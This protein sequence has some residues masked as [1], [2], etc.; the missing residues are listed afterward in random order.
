MSGS[1]V[2]VTA[3]GTISALALNSSRHFERLLAGHSALSALSLP[4]YRN[5][6]P[7]LQASIQDFDR[8]ELIP[9]RML[10][11]LLSPSPA[12]ALA[13]TTEAL[14]NAGLDAADLTGCGLY[15][16]SVC[17]DANPEALIP[18]LRAS[19]NHL[20]ELDLDRFANYGM[21]LVDPLFLVKSL[22]NAGLCAI[23]IQHQVLGA[24]ANLTNGGVSGLQAVAAAF[25]AIRCGELEFAIA[26]AYDSLLQMD[27][28]VEHLLAGRLTQNGFPPEQACRPFDRHR[29]GY[30]LGEGAAFLILESLDHARGR[31]AEVYGEILSYG[32]TT[33]S[34]LLVETEAGDGEALVVAARQTLDCGGEAAHDIDAVFGDGN[35]VCTDDQRESCA[36]QNLFPCGTVPFTSATAAIGYT[37]AA[38]GAFGL[39]H[40]FLAMKQGVLPPTINCDEPAPEC[41]LPVVHQ[42]RA[43]DLHK[44]LVWNSDRGIKNAAMLIGD[45]AS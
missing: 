19:I 2:V 14:K 31:Q 27:C 39:V 5:F 12:Y 6:P 37:G 21:K 16:G 23:A 24:N 40:A 38:S 9:D 32:D 20:D 18:A 33:D 25:E 41:A 36:Y 13:S 44:V 26:G 30:A 15:V 28:V 3:V 8:R 34:R 10:R 17:L 22:P 7:I 29:S 4:E 1:R 35:G 45:C 42:A 11:K 43:A